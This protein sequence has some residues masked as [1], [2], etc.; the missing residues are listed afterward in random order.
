MQR[1]TINA[2]VRKLRKIQEQLLAIS[3]E[4]GEV[5]NFIMQQLDAQ[6]DTIEG[7]ITEINDQTENIINSH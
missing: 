1:K 6:R 5:D 7:I 4:F 2:N 3:A